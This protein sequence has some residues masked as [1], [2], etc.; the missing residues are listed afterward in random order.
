MIHST[1]SNVVSQGPCE[2]CGSSDANTTYDDRHQFCFSCE[3]YIGSGEAPDQADA[4]TEAGLVPVEIRALPA[5]GIKEETCR[6]YS[7]GIHSGEQIAQ[8][9]DSNGKVVAQK[10]RTKNKEF[11][12]LGDLKRA[13][14]FGQHL[15]KPG[16]KNLLITEG[17]ID[18]LSM[19]QVQGNKWPCVS[20]PN[21]ASGA[22]KAIQA[23]LSW[24][25]SFERVVICFDQDEPGQ[26]AALAVAQL[27]APGKAAIMKFEGKDPNELLKQ[28]RTAELVQAFWDAIPFRP[29]GLMTGAQLWEAVATATTP[30]SVAYPHTGLQARTDGM[31][32]GQIITIAAGPACGKTTFCAEIANHLIDNGHKVGYISLEQNERSTL[33]SLLTPQVDRALHRIPDLNLNDYKEAW[34]RIGPSLTVY[35]HCGRLDADSLEEKARFMAKAD[36]CGFIFVDNLSIVV[37]STAGADDRQ[38]IDKIM[39]R[40]V[41]LVQETDV[42]LFLVVHLKRSGMG[43]AYSEGRIPRMEDVRGSGLIEA[44]SHDMIGL[45]RDQKEGTATEVTLLKCRQTG[46]A[47]RCGW[48]SYNS[49]SGRLVETGEPAG[50]EDPTEDF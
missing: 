9:R 19:S 29:D 18:C 4:F 24:V 6:R 21:G 43:E 3:T 27:L 1:E 10:V 13:C 40:L 33:L 22:V 26:K 34:D 50:K 2:A 7:Y 8:Y 5:R 48:L 45:S 31:R 46:E 25:E 30:V 12:V 20:I 41:S 39:Q 49:A 14:L 16:G 17:E 11:F 23:Q 47:G 44:F 36:G 28:K 15:S 37:S 42:T 38:E 32:A 35:R